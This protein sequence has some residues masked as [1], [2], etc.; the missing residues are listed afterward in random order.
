MVVPHSAG[1]HLYDADGGAF[2]VG[3]TLQFW[4]VVCVSAFYIECAT[5]KHSKTLENMA[6]LKDDVVMARCNLPLP[7]F[8]RASSPSQTPKYERCVF[9]PPSSLA[10]TT[11]HYVDVTRVLDRCIGACRTDY[12]QFIIDKLL[13]TQTSVEV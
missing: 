11:I 8:S 3:G 10:A 2:V 6:D 5:V 13:Q 1:R 4:R 12:S 7:D 9:P